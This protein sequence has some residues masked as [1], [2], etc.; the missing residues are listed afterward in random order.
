MALLCAVN[1]KKHPACLVSAAE[2]PQ[3]ADG[4]ATMFGV[5]PDMIP[6]WYAPILNQPTS[7]PMMTRM[8]GLCC[9]AHTGAPANIKE[10]SIASRPIRNFITTGLLHPCNEI[11]QHGAA[12][13]TPLLGGIRISD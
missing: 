7:S 2:A 5:L 13:G 10:A 12:A 4:F 1:R 6:R 3:L 8:L 9:C 11:L